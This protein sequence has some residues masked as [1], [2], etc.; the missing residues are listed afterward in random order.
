M[1]FWGFAD[2]P[3]DAHEFLEGKSRV[4]DLQEGR[5]QKLKRGLCDF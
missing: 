3:R 1:L 2:V 5:L 4:V